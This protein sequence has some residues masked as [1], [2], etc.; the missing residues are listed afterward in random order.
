MLSVFTQSLNELECHTSTAQ[1]DKRICVIRS[2]GA[3]DTV[4]R[5]EIILNIMMIR[6]DHLDPAA[7]QFLNGIYICYTAIDCND[8]IRILL[9]DFIHD[10]LGKP[11]T[12]LGSVR[13]DILHIHMMTPEIPDKDRSGRYTV[14]VVVAVHEHLAVSIDR[15]IDDIHGFSHVIIKERIVPDPVSVC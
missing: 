2:L 8:Q 15:L 5:R 6:Y 10:L 14:T 13:N 9:N 4:S 3:N 12:V 7:L 1:I 11:V